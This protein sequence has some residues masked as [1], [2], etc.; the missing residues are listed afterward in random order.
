MSFL[1]QINELQSKLDLESV[2]AAV[3]TRI[4]N[5]KADLAELED[6]LKAVTERINN[7][8]TEAV[9]ATQAKVEEVAEVVKE[10]VKKAAPKKAPAKKAAP[11]KEEDAPEKDA[12][13]DK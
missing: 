11:K 3:E 13:S 9:E 10:E 6:H 12:P 1:N 7:F 8:A 5:T 4:E 2:K